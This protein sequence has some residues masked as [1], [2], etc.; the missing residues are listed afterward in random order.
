MLNRL[1]E[2]NFIRNDN[3]LE[4]IYHKIPREQKKKLNCLFVDI[5]G[6]KWPKIKS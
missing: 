1:K 6:C 4:E 2:L 3:K 5:G